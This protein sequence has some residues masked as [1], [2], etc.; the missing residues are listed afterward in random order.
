METTY[1]ATRQ[2]ACPLC[3]GEPRARFSKYS[4]PI[5]DCQQ[6]RHRYAGVYTTPDH[7]TQLY[8]DDYFTK[9]GAG[10]INYLQEQELH[11]RRGDYYSK[12]LARHCKPGRLLDVGAAAGYIMQ[13]FKDNGWEVHGVEPNANIAAYARESLGLDVQTADFTI[14]KSH[15]RYD[16]VNLIQ[17]I[18]HLPNP[19]A[20][21]EKVASLNTPKGYCL[22]ETWNCDS[23]VSKILGRHWHEYSPP[24]VLHWFSPARL[25]QL[26][27]QHGY[28]VVDRGR[29]SRQIT[30]S[31]AKSLLRHALA[32]HGILK[33]LLPL[34]DLIPDR[35]SVPYPPVDLFWTLYQKQS[36]DG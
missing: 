12:I 15:E 28:T 30:G 25:D 2:V 6:C 22:V 3:G 9:G 14:F 8:S 18:A 19:H 5:N 23:L 36:T 4:I 27:R 13:G 26:F 29:P 20:A 24:S 31:H 10:Y 1:E 21:L 7:T 35:L 17:V 16:L 34:L 11:A 32:E 33:P